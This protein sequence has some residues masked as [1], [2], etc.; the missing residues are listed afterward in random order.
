MNPALPR[1]ELHTHLEGSVTPR[2]L[3]QLGERHGET[4][5]AA[6]CLDPAG[7]RF[8]FSGFLGF[9][10][11]Y[12]HVTLLLKTPRDFHEVALDLGEA[13]HRDRVGYAEVS[14]SYAVMQRWGLDPLA[15]Q[16]ALHEAACEVEETRG[17]RL[18]WIPDATRQWGLDDAYRAFE[19]AAQAGRA[20]GVVGFGL[21]GDEA[22]GPAR[23]FAH[24]FADVRDEGLGVTIHAGEVPAMGAEAAADSVRQAVEE[25]GA[26]RIGHGLAAARDPAVMALLAAR[27]VHVELCPGSNLKTG[28]IARL[29]DHPLQDFLAAGISCGLNPDDRTLFDLDQERELAAARA[30]LRLDA[31]QEAWMQARSREAAFGDAD[32]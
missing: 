26:R 30:E 1:V 27:Q 15:V 21:G 10:E 18:R 2:R 23:D 17:V 9:L 25:C 11:L 13:L 12:K 6:R 31:Q 8:V 29:A 7:R 3:I 20:L 4:A 24:L 28:A 19:A 14:L 32:A 5:R 16:Q 22:K